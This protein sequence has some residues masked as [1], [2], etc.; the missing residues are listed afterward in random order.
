MKLVI[1]DR[2][3]VI[4]YDSDNYIK[5]VDE[6][7]PIPG[8]IE[9]IAELCKAGFEVCI[10]TNQSGLAR[11]YFSPETL[12]AMHVKMTSLVTAAGGSIKHIEHCPHG[13][14]DSCNCRKPLPGMI[15][16][17]LSKHPD[18]APESVYVVGD[19]LRDLEA[20]VSA[21]CKT[22]LVKTGKGERTLLKGNLPN[23]TVICDNLS[24]AVKT[25]TG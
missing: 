6:W 4:N 21:G 14:D 23:G 16:D 25:I 18:T 11:G 15:T 7:Q 5:T 12:S 20:G 2:D 9:A 10:A 22:L 24:S 13:P 17:I 8:S 1:L 3:G 19:S